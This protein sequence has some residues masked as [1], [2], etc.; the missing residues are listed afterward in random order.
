MAPSSML[1]RTLGFQ[2]SKFGSTPN[3]AIINMALSNKGK[4]T[5]L[6]T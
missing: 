4:F 6:S 2:P 3:G 5:R 1:V